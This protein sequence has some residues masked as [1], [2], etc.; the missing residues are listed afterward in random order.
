M[1]E[2]NKVRI[3]SNS[4][5]DGELPDITV[6]FED[7]GTAYRFRGTYEGRRALPAKLLR[8]MEHD[9]NTGKGADKR[10]GTR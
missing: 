3:T 2:K 7:G 5:L 6:S 1:D 10:D 8:L 9:E 4:L